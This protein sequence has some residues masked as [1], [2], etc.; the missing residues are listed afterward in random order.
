M[1]ESLGH[2]YYEEAEDSSSSS[3]DREREEGDPI[4]EYLDEFVSP[5]GNSAELEE[6]TRAVNYCNYD[7]VP[8]HSDEPYQATPQPELEGPIYSGVPRDEVSSSTRPRA[9]RFLACN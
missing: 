9:P 5:E 3:G 2:A 1:D 7:Y 4:P 8:E 6:V